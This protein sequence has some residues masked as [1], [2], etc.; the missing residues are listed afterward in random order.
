[1]NPDR[2]FFSILTPVFNPPIDAFRACVQS[3]LDQEY[4]NWEW[5]IVDDAADQ[6]LVWTAIEDLAYLDERIRVSRRSENGG[7]VAASNDAASMAKGRFVCLLDHDDMLHPTALTEV[8]AAIEARDSVDYV[9]TDEDKI[10]SDGNHYDVFLKP[11]WSPERLRG[12]NYC[13]H[14]SVI[15]KE[16][17][18]QV[19]GF[20]QGFD[21]SQDYDLILRVT[22]MARR[23][24]HIPKV[25][26]HWRAVDGSTASSIDEKPYAFRAA[27][28]ALK[29]HLQRVG[30][31]GDV[32][33]AGFGY[34]KVVRRMTDEPLV[35]IVIPTRGDSKLIRASR[36]SLVLRCVDSILANRHSYANFELIIVADTS[37]PFEVISELEK[38]QATRVVPYDKPF[39]FSDKCNVGFLHSKGDVIVLLNDDT[40]VITV[41]WLATLVALAITPD[42]GVVGPMLLLEDGRIQSAGHSNTPSPH[43]FRSGHSANQ[44]G[45]FGILAVARECSGVTGAAMAIRRE[46]YIEAGGMSV[47]F[48]NCFN[49]VDFCFKVLELGYRIIWTPHSRLFHYESITRTPDVAEMELCLLYRRWGR[50]FDADRLCRL[51]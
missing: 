31:Q 30:I 32:E 12:Q 3:V 45:E 25:L 48:A 37:T 16:L 49:D 34:H 21:G 1:M 10:D 26:Y 46:V 35:S 47:S 51:N 4:Q 17:F 18:D 33:D 15:R 11:A 9:Y 29:D 24:E 13:C 20:R 8:A 14:L 27:Q 38:K 23:I 2:P 42:V 5:C 36:R 7:I 41:D 44:P 39:N 19:G 50:F 43:N 6:S 22:E 40:E 28:I